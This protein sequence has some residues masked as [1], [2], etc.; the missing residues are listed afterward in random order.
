MPSFD[1]LTRFDERFELDE[2][3]A[4]SGIHYQRTAAAWREKIESNKDRVVAVFQDVY[5]SDAKKWYHR[6]RLFF[7]ACEELFGYRGGNEWLVG[8]YRFAPL[9]HTTAPE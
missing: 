5:G 7:L 3:W 2:R 9:Q 1:L 6:W 8:H 4:V